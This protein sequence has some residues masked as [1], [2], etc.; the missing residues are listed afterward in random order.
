MYYLYF[1]LLP[2]KVGSFEGCKMCVVPSCL[3]VV[4]VVSVTMTPAVC[5]DFS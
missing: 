3:N 1:F 4:S 5:G 2:Q